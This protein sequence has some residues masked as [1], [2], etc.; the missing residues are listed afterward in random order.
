MSFQGI[1]V[2]STSCLTRRDVSRK[3]LTVT[4]AVDY[5]SSFQESFIIS[6]PPPLLS[7]WGSHPLLPDFNF[8]QPVTFVHAPRQ[9]HQCPQ[10]KLQQA[11]LNL[12]DESTNGKHSSIWVSD[13]I[14]VP[15]S[16]LDDKNREFV[17]QAS[18]W[19]QSLIS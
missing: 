13:T 9:V 11:P 10:S 8:S 18:A 14:T 3:Y 17:L 16:T 19:K 12:S 1:E 5:L 15:L 7:Y 6:F 2:V 4:T